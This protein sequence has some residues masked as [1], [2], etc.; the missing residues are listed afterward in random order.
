MRLLKSWTLILAMVL[1]CFVP[2]GSARQRRAGPSAPPAEPAPQPQA[3]AAIEPSPFQLEINEISLMSKNRMIARDNFKE[4]GRFRATLSARPGLAA[5]PTQTD[6]QVR[7]GNIATTDVRNGALVLGTTSLVPLRSSGTAASALNVN[8]GDPAPD[9]A[10][11]EVFTDAFGSSFGAL[12]SIP[13]SSRGVSTAFADNRT[14]Q[15]N[16]TFAGKEMFGDLVFSAR[17]HAASL[18]GYETFT[19]GITDVGARRPAGKLSVRR[20][21]IRLESISMKDG[22]WPWTETLLD[23]VDLTRMQGI[24]DVRLTFMVDAQGRMSGLAEVTS[25]SGVQRFKLN[26]RGPQAVL[27]PSYDKYAASIFVEILPKPRI[28]QVTPNQMARGALLRRGGTFTVQVN[29][30]GFGPDTRVELI[31]EGRGA[32]PVVASSVRI[33]PHNGSLE[34]TFRTTGAPAQSYSVRVTTAGQ[35]AVLEKALSLR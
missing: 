10:R 35:T 19:L 7:Y 18:K 20:D 11:P 9:R 25:R 15:G 8:T 32:V 5:A 3:A 29:G 16:S 21:S 23:Q 31:P 27:D 12:F 22:Q 13:V 26:G 6:Y 17:V 30:V 1:G 33:A 28:A 14:Y 24:S 2:D 34:A 4:T